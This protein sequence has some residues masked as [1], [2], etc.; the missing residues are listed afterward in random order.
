MVGV[1]LGEFAHK[2]VVYRE[3]RS[4]PHSCYAKRAGSPLA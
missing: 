3:G 4:G 1:G 2:S